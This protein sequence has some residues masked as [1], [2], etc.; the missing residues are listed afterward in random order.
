MKIAEVVGSGL[1]NGFT[2]ARSAAL[3]QKIAAAFTPSGQ[4][5]AH[6][7]AA[8][9]GGQQAARETRAVR[10]TDI[11]PSSPVDGLASTGGVQPVHDMNVEPRSG[12]K[13]PFETSAVLRHSVKRAAG[14]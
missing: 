1:D 10:S 8:G 2:N 7:D 12:M 6:W 5:K 3:M 11:A 13:E 4:V 9:L 14:W